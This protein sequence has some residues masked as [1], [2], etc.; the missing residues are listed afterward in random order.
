MT[1]KFAWLLLPSFLAPLA[2]A[3][4]GPKDGG[5]SPAVTRLD[6]IRAS[7]LDHGSITVEVDSPNGQRTAQYWPNWGKWPNWG[8]FWFNR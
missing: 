3:N 4:A 5:E 6:E 8:N 7:L 1:H 2:G